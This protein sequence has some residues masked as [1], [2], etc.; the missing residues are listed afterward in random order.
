M[1]GIHDLGGMHGFGP[2][3]REGHEMDGSAPWEQTVQGLFRVALAQRL[4]NL[5]EFRHGI[6]RMDP[7]RYLEA[8][9]YDRW[10]TS[11]ECILIEKGVVTEEELEAR[12]ALLNDHPTTSS[13][14]A[15]PPDGP[16]RPAT[17]P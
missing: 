1:D 15:T 14:P 13:S 12:T 2:V 7:L 6:E 16:A 8:A 11:V 17:R 9:Y 5:D 4:L 10:Y 3:P